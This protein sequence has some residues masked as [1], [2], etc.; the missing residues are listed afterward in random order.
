MAFQNQKLSLKNVSQ[1][2]KHKKK[3]DPVSYVVVTSAGNED[4]ETRD[5][6]SNIN[7]NCQGGVRATYQRLN[8]TLHMNRH[9]GG[10]KHTL[11]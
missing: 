10:H 6:H 3:L 9:T 11:I 4:W 8:L 2:S 5:A 7:Q 1:I